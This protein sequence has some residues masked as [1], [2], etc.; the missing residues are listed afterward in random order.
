MMR[1]YKLFRAVVEAYILELG[2]NTSEE[3]SN[4]LFVTRRDELLFID[5][6]LWK[7]V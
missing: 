5:G 2:A 1:V 6:N 4:E 7:E 3:V